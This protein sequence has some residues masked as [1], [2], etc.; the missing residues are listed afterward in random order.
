MDFPSA[1]SSYKTGFDSFLQGIKAIRDY[2]NQT[3]KG[4]P[5]ALT[6]GERDAIRE[7]NS[8]ALMSVYP[9]GSSAQ[10]RVSFARFAES[11]SNPLPAAASDYAD[12]LLRDA[13]NETH[14]KFIE[15]LDNIKVHQQYKL[16]ATQL[17]DRT[18]YGIRD[19]PV[20][21]DGVDY[22]LSV[23][24]FIPKKTEAEDRNRNDVTNTNIRL[25]RQDGKTIL[26]NGNKEINLSAHRNY[27]TI[28]EDPLKS[29]WQTEEVNNKLF[30]FALGFIDTHSIKRQS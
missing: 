1:L 3:M 7:A 13:H 11:L 22:K 17:Q 23:F 25:E 24:A 27:S 30:Q 5:P 18:S 8:A 15:A 9:V 21:I 6:P 16:T 26:T 29:D 12:T 2:A 4:M 20:S 10:D 19:I 14:T 28:K